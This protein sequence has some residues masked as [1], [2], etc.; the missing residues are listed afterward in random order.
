MSSAHVIA[1]HD[2]RKELLVASTVN[3]RGGNAPLGEDRAASALFRSGFATFAGRPNTGKSSLINAVMGKKVAITSSKAQTTRTRLR[4]V[5]TRPE[6]QLIMVDTPGLHKPQ[7][8]LGSTL[9]AAALKSLEDVDVAAMFIDCSQP[10]GRG[11][12]WVARHIARARCPKILVLSKCDLADA[13]QLERQRT[14]AASLVPWDAQAVCSARTG[15]GVEALVDLL[16]SM[17]PEGPLWF[18]ADM[19]TDQSVETAVA[20]F[21]REKI[22]R[23]FF[24]EV[25]HAIG[26]Q[27]EEMSFDADRDTETVRAV[28]YVERDS[29]KGMVIGKGGRAIKRIGSEARADLETLL[30]SHV[31]LDLRVKVK[32]NWRRDESQVRRFGYGEGL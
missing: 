12:E 8:A 19:D 18:P 28:I 10:V 29:Q 31:F 14:A 24:D 25:P 21:V 16:V 4:A 11:D 1:F 30:G 3:A 32:K 22:L 20:E 9:N 7:D 27:V 2:D 17:L 13:D 5:L 23:S 15:E 26:V 6:S